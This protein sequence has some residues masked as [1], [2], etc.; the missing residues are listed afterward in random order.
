VPTSRPRR[1]SASGSHRDRSWLIPQALYQNFTH[2]RGQGFLVKLRQ[3]DQP[4]ALGDAQPDADDR[5]RFVGGRAAWRPLG[6]RVRHARS[7]HARRPTDLQKKTYPFLSPCGPKTPKSR[8]NSEGAKVPGSLGKTQNAPLFEG[9][10]R[11]GTRTAK[12]PPPVQIRA[13]PPILLS[14]FVTFA[15]ASSLTIPKLTLFYPCQPGQ[16]RRRRA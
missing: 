9:P 2:H 8:Q 12:P 6:Q 3:A 14:V 4:I 15:L 13:A 7:E 5:S 16:L 10:K 11:V 1:S